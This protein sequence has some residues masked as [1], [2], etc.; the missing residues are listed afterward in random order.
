LRELEPDVSAGTVLCDP[1]QHFFAGII[2]ELDERV[3]I[4]EHH[5]LG[6]RRYPVM[7]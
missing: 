5:K 1:G 7:L 2:D 3:L 4:A 6:V